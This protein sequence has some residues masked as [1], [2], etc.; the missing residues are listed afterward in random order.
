MADSPRQ[1]AL[2]GG[3]FDPVHHGHLIVARALAEDRGFDRIVLVPAACPPHKPAAHASAEHRLA[4]LQLAV[5]GEELFEVS[6]VELERTGPS[7]TY[8]TLCQLRRQFGGGTVLHWVIGADM[9][10][11]LP[12]W[13]RAREIFDVANI[14][15]VLRPPW[16]LKIQQVLAKLADEFNANL[17]EQLRQST[18]EGPLIE[19]SS[20]QIRGR[21]AEGRSIRHLTPCSVISYIY[22][23][24]LYG[25]GGHGSG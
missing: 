20:T 6:A 12:Q 25:T 1:L 13:H 16:H 17:A 11:D 4:M 10:E 18:W 14:L 2:F 9:L 5:A 7:F 23:H 24:G 21:L 22:S 8:D 3:S 19:L 15:V